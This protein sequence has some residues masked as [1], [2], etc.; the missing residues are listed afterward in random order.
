MYFSKFPILQYPVKDGAT[1]R[2]AFVRNILRRIAVS[3]P[4]KNEGGVFV[5]Y[6]LKDGERPEHIAERVYGDPAFHWLVLLVNETIDPHHGWCKSEAAMEEYM[7]KK[8]GGH[9]V[10]VTNTSDGFL[11]S[12]SIVS[13]CS[14]TQNGISTE[15][16]D[17]IPELCKLTVRGSVPNSGSASIG[18]TSGSSISV[19]VHRVDESYVAVNHFEVNRPAADTGASS[20]F[21]VD[22]LSQQNTSYSVVG[23]VIGYEENEYPNSAQGLTYNGSGVVDLYETYIGKYMGISG[24]AVGIYAVSNLTEETRKNEAKRKIKVLHPRYKNLAVRELESLLRV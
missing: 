16:L 12:S 17:F 1:T 20:Y 7:M 11:Y 18:L 9:S 19:K 8:Y 24:S 4:L 6:H 22:P 10:Y 2:Y 14:F 23:G 13:G 3:E 15:I 21:T 5:E